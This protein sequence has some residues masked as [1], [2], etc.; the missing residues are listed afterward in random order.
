MRFFRN[1]ANA[2]YFNE[3]RMPRTREPL[4][5][6]SNESQGNCRGDS[7]GAYRPQA[8]DEV[9]ERASVMSEDALMRKLQEL[10]FMA[11]ELEL[12][13]DAYPDSADAL[14]TYRRSTAELAALTRQY[15]ERFGP[16]TAR[17]SRGERWT[18]TT[19]K[20]PWQIE[21]VR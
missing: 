19:G 5:F 20:W 9:R 11:V 4:P 12:Y 17:S 8:R 14:E 13:L 15:E 16:L 2:S 7:N 1:E 10:S 21:E 18:W 6:S 3:S